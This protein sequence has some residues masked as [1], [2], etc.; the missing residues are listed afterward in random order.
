M[1]VK[2]IDEDVPAKAHFFGL[3][4]ALIQAVR[5]RRAARC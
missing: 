3:D 4:P 1:V 2:V 5:T